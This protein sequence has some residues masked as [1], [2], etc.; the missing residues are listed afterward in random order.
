MNRYMPVRAPSSLRR[1]LLLLG[2]LAPALGLAAPA[3]APDPVGSADDRRTP[4]F[5]RDHGSHPQTRI[6]WWYITGHTRIG[7]GATRKE[8]GFQLTFFRA[9]VEA[10]QQLASK[11]AARQ[12][13]FAHAALSDVTGSQFRHDQRI[14]REGFGIAQASERDMDLRLRNWSLVRRDDRYQARI[15]GGDFTLEL[16]FSP[17]TAIVLQGDPRL[18]NP[19]GVIVVNPARHPHVK[20]EMAQRFAD[21]VVSPTGQKA[22][23][24]YKIGGEQLFFPNA[25]P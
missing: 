18:F 6:E 19:Y 22:I 4:D 21:W 8:L 16:D 20:R 5:P 25:K 2:G 11:F 24:D 13:L 9:R 3:A 7:S 15:L 23:A 17:T 12:L 14:A 1:Q 10:T